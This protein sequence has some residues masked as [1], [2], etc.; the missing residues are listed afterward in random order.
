MGALIGFELAR[1]L[2]QLA[3]AAPFRL[4][5][6][7]EAAPQ[8]PKSA[9]FTYNLPEEE[10]ISVVRNTHDIPMEVIEHPELIHILLPLLRADTQLVESYSYVP[11]PPLEIPISAYGWS[12]D[13]LS[14]RFNIEQ[15]S[16]Q[17]AGR[18]KSKNF[19]CN[20]FHSTSVQFALLNEVNADI[21]AFGRREEMDANSL[22][23][24]DIAR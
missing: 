14:S 22:P 6:A 5:V 7:D 17:T 9:P 15:W 24:T 8:V 12:N 1:R 16:T 19:V 11:G 3:G 21:F 20:R 4:I 18:F 2:S 13:P 23:S 10:F